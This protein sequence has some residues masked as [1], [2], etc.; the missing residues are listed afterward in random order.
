MANADK[1]IM[2]LLKYEVRINEVRRK[3]MENTKL[4]FLIFLNYRL[5]FES[6][7]TIRDFLWASGGG[8]K[9]IKMTTRMIHTSES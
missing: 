4:T 5:L 8:V 2:G 1:A 9:A 3:N 6:S 7:R